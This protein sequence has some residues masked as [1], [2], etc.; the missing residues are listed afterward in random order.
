MFLGTLSVC[1]TVLVLNIH[2]RDSE[3]PVPKWVRVL[4][5][6]YLARMLC[7][8]GRKPKSLA[9]LERRMDIETHHH[10]HETSLVEGLRQVTKDANI[11]QPL[12]NGDSRHNTHA[13]SRGCHH[14]KQYTTTVTPTTPPNLIESPTNENEARTGA[15]AGGGG[16]ADDFPLLTKPTTTAA[17]KRKKY[18]HN[19]AYEWKEVA[20]ILDQL[21]FIL[22]LVFMTASF[23]IIIFVPFYKQ[24]YK[25]RETVDPNA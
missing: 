7:V 5:F 1:M 17:E 9:E 19:N 14:Q 16:G 23:M 2:H 22:M 13:H 11:L 3:R 21:F 8:T 15:S 18:W 6:K 4:C 10:K 24:P 20:H 25:P 12:M